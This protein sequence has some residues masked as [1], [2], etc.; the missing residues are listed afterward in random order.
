MKPTFIALVTAAWLVSGCG[1]PTP[2]LDVDNHYDIIPQPLS[3]T[4]SQG[5]F[6]IDAQ[7]SVSV[8]ADGAEAQRVAQRFVEE[9]SEKTGFDLSSNPAA[10]K[11]NIH[12][13]ISD[14]VAH[15]EGYQLS[16]HPKRVVITARE[17]RGLFYAVQTLWQLFPTWVASGQMPPGEPCYLP[18]VEIAD[19]PR[20]PYRGMHLDVAR[21]FFDVEAVKQYI[22]QLAYHK[23]NFFHWHLTED[24]GWRIEIKQYPRL[25]EVGA[26]RNGTL[27]GHYNDQPHR[28]D[29]QRYGG[30]YTQEEV[31]AIV[32][33]AAE[34][35]ITVV[36][37]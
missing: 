36:P 12:F 1:S 13:V 27:I 20:F 15:P 7:T 29:G 31:K 5:A 11:N 3:L 33:Y 14:Q 16:I 24:Q 2:T 19:Q 4:P 28:F 9:L 26:Y 8:D 22:D 32:A 23:M 6:V 34:R 18:A 35:F 30:F 17:P 21:H 37:N 25:T 10:K